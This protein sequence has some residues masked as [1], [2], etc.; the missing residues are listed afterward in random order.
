MPDKVSQAE[1]QK[2]EKAETV[3]VLY[4]SAAIHCHCASDTLFLPSP[5]SNPK[6]AQASSVTKMG[7]FNQA[8]KEKYD[9]KTAKKE[10][11]RADAATTRGE[12]FRRSG[13]TERA[14][15]NK[16]YSAAVYRQSD[17]D[18]V[19]EHRRLKRQLD[20]SE[21]SVDVSSALI[22][23]KLGIAAA[24]AAG[25]GAGAPAVPVL[26]AGLL[27]AKQAKHAKLG[28]QKHRVEQEL[29]YRRG[30]GCLERRMRLRDLEHAPG[31]DRR[32]EDRR[33]VFRKSAAGE[34]AGAYYDR[35][36]TADALRHV[37]SLREARD[38][39]SDWWGP[40]TAEVL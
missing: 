7:L 24:A 9:Q 14:L 28:N 13:L 25:S 22:T 31:Y 11:K 5:T 39:A 33:S 40:F 1:F 34:A 23:G 6:L 19:S 4:L 36:D 26:G 30:K 35:T 32:S 15:F 17:A 20:K 38:L 2:T 37:H 27:L 29:E 8:A 10:A 18:L 16:D 3:S 21:F 12:S